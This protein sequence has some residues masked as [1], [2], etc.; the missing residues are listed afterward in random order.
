VRSSAIAEKS[1]ALAKKATR[2]LASIYSQYF[3]MRNAQTILR[4]AVSSYAITCALVTAIVACAFFESHAA[5]SAPQFSVQTLDGG[6]LTSGSLAGQMVLLQFWATWCPYCR[7]DQPA[8]D[9]VGRAYASQG[10]MVLAVDVGESEQTVRAYLQKSP[11][12]CQVA[13]DP[14]HRMAARFGASSYPYYVL[15]DRNGAVA[16][17][18]HGAGGEESLRHLIDRSGLGS[19]TETASASTRRAPVTAAASQVINVPLPRS[20]AAAKPLPKTLFFFRSGEKLEADRYV[21]RAGF[22][23]LTVDGQSRKI[24]LSELDMNKTAAANHERG[25]DLVMPKNDSEVFLSF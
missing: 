10:L 20:S 19:N 5:G 6:T 18:V 22:L 12:S 23:Q 17:S 9:E 1:S 25:V 13:L 2:M 8:V 15:L 11:R 4:H 7:R 24:P 21:I 14:D 3:D 16:G